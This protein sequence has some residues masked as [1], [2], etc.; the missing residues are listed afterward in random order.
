[1]EETKI[2][3]ILKLAK[4]KTMISIATVHR[5][6]NIGLSPHSAHIYLLEMEISGLL[7][8]VEHKSAGRIFKF[9]RNADLEG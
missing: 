8:R 7:K 3:K 2:N 1:M 5:D 6:K 9:W 4:E